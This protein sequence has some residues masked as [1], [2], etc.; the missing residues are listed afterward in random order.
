MRA[1]HTLLVEKLLTPLRHIVIKCLIVR[2]LIFLYEN[3]QMNWLF[4]PKRC[5]RVLFFSYLLYEQIHNTYLS[6]IAYFLIY[7]WRRCLE[8]EKTVININ[9][10]LKFLVGVAVLLK[11][12]NKINYCAFWGIFDYAL[13]YQLVCALWKL[14]QRQL[15]SS[16]P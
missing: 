6:Y 3:K 1:G 13:V 2:R 14:K 12:F 7:K 11:L 10:F 16:I 15:C 5:A 8:K 4:I 9:N